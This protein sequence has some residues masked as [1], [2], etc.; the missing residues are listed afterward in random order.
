LFRRRKCRCRHELTIDLAFQARQIQGTFSVKG[1]TI[2][3]STP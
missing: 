2:A 3:V 1:V